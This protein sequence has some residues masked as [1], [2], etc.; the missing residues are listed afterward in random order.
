MDYKEIRFESDIETFLLSYAGGY[1]KGDMKRY[2]KDKALDMETL[3]SFVKDTQP[4]EWDRFERMTVSDVEKK[5][6]KAINDAIN[7]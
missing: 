6:F 3:I 5:F 2:N 1:Q 4:K 7:N